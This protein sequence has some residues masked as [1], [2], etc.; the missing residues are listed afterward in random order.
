M[1]LI[2]LGKNGK[3]TTYVYTLYEQSLREGAYWN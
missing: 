3:P 2:L 1:V